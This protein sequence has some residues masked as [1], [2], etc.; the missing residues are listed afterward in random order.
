MRRSARGSTER[1]HVT[2]RRVT[3]EVGVT[4]LKDLWDELLALTSRNGEAFGIFYVRRVMSYPFDL[5]A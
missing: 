1:R 4:P 5:R 3:K 2:N